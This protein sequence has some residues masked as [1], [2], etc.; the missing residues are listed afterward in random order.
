MTEK[1]LISYIFTHYAEPREKKERKKKVYSV[2][3]FSN[4]AFSNIWLCIQ[5]T[6]LHEAFFRHSVHAQPSVPGQIHFC[7]TACRQITWGEETRACQPHISPNKAL[8]MHQQLLYTD[9]LHRSLSPLYQTDM[10]HFTCLG[11]HCLPCAAHSVGGPCA[12]FTFHSSYPFHRSYPCL[13]DGAKQD[14]PCKF[15]Q[16]VG[17][18]VMRFLG[19]T[20]RSHRKIY[21]QNTSL[22][23]CF[24]KK[25]K[26]LL[27]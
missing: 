1:A 20:P 12:A 24:F 3:H 19:L 17:K 21:Q 27:K 18:I 9:L 13:L 5:S 15:K 2:P 4:F 14:P 11:W 23:C 10:L 25:A 22:L 26:T 8:A 6:L 16:I 7:F